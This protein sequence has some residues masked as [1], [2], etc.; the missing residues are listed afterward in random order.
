MKY[1]WCCV[2]VK[3]R[4]GRDGQ[5]GST[6]V[7]AALQ[8]NCQ[9]DLS[10]LVLSSILPSFL[11]LLGTMPL[12][13]SAGRWYDGLRA[14][15]CSLEQFQRSPLKPQLTFCEADGAIWKSDV[16]G[17]SPA[18]LSSVGQISPF[19]CFFFSSWP[20]AVFS[21]DRLWCWIENLLLIIS[22]C[23]AARAKQH[24]CHG[25]P[26][27]LPWAE[28]QLSPPFC[29]EPTWAIC[30]CWDLWKPIST[31]ASSPSPSVWFLMEPSASECF[32]LGDS[33]D[34]RLS[35]FSSRGQAC[36]SYC[37]RQ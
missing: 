10:K 25:S 31:N 32:I 22:W 7:S 14:V 26:F 2:C 11:C 1:P 9:M 19:S 12:P 30:S 24:L 13:P 37:H 35:G 17:I 34:N 6:E 3:D 16:G 23:V 8:G 36:Q 28:A 33:V 18:S 21:Q 27:L 4:N 20:Q 29:S 5:T 15:G